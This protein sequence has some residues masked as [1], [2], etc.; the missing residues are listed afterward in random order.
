[1][2]ILI[3]LITVMSFV[4]SLSALADTKIIKNYSIE[5]GF[6]NSIGGLLPDSIKC[7][8]QLMK[9]KEFGVRVTKTY[10]REAKPIL[11]KIAKAS[12]DLKFKPFYP[13]SVSTLASTNM[14]GLISINNRKT[15]KTL[16]S[17]TATVAHE[18]THN[19]GYKHDDKIFPDVSYTVGEIIEDLV[20]EGRCS[21]TVETEHRSQT[22]VNHEVE[23]SNPRPATKKRFSLKKFIF[24][25]R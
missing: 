13:N 3:T 6:N 2:R 4:L 5:P 14:V 7:T 17:L 1:M 18:T 9:S 12:F 20:R 19:L 16:D 25:L 8:N 22:P 11:D 24:R 23:S 15:N 10:G 21:G